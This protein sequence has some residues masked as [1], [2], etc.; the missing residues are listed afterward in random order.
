MA[1]ITVSQLNKYVSYY[2]KEN[3][4]INNIFVKGEI[5][6]LKKHYASGHYYF[7]LKDSDSSIKAC[8]F[9]NHVLNMKFN[10]EN[11]M[12]V[13]V[14]GAAGLYERDGSFQLYVSDISPVGIGSEQL[15]LMQLKE[16]LSEKGYFS[17]EHKKEIPNFPEKIGV[18]TSA[19][20][21]AIK[22]IINVLSRRYPFAILKVFDTAVQG[23]KAVDG[24]CRQLLTADDSD[25]D[26]I[27]LSRGGGS[28]EDLGIF[29]DERI[30]DV[31]YNLKTPIISAIGH[32]IDYTIPDYIADLRAPTPSAAAELASVSVDVIKRTIKEYENLLDK[33]IKHNL[34]ELRS[35]TEINDNKLNIIRNGLMK[36]NVI[37]CLNKLNTALDISIKNKIADIRQITERYNYLLEKNNVN[38]IMTRGFFAVYREDQVIKNAKELRAGDILKLV[39]HDG[40][41][42]VKVVE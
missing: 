14:F 24:L 6:N 35:V 9:R 13:V 40:D 27:I 28:S 31:V 30:A 15:A 23:K 7:T 2:L 18:V 4:V 26:V 25:C 1:V 20:G 16:K 42:T 10:I 29:N 17:D 21:A 19:N 34:A 5:I 11:G 39:T 33:Q 32:E 3:K 36:H 12:S 41:I 8:M 22:D 38:E 37:M